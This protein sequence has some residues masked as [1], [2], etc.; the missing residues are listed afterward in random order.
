MDDADDVSVLFGQEPAS[1][2]RAKR[3][4][5]AV[6]DTAASKSS[7]EIRAHAEKLLYWANRASERSS[8]KSDA[9]AASQ[10][11]SRSRQRQGTIASNAKH[12]LSPIPKTIGL[13]PR[14]QSRVRTSSLLPPQPPSAPSSLV[15]DGN[16]AAKGDKENGSP[17][18]NVRGEVPGAFPTAPR[19]K[20]NV[21]L[22]EDD[23]VIH[24]MDYVDG[25]DDVCC[26]CTVSPFSGNDAQSEFYLPKLGLACNCAGGNSS[27]DDRTSFL[28]DPPALS[29]ILR[30]WQCDFLATL[31]VSAAEELLRAHKADANGK[32][33]RMRR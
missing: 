12:V 21:S 17:T 28:K 6:E 25:D 15:S 19:Q 7:Q 22:S 5:T 33:R 11:P 32:A 9:S 14:S 3:D 4:G 23:T 10:Q 1:G 16:N 8:K 20:K 13:P 26:E 30:P 27:H 24:N 31:G 29:N 2:K 18:F